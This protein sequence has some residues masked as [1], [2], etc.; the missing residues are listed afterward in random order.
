M[1][2]LYTIFIGLSFAIIGSGVV[3]LLFKN[4]EFT[5]VL[6]AISPV[7]FQFF[8]ANQ[9]SYDDLASKT[10][11]GGTL[12][13]GILAIVGVTGLIKY[14]SYMILDRGKI[15]ANILLLFL[16]LALAFSSVIYS[17]D[18]SN[19]LMR[20]SFLTTVFF[21]L[22]G[23]SVWLDTEDNF[24]K[25]LNLLFKTIVVLVIM[26]L[27]SLGI[28]GRSFWWKQP[29]FIGF[30][31]HPQQLGAFFMV[32]YPIILWKTKSE[33]QRERLFAYMILTI[34]IVL[35]LLTATRSPMFAAV[36]GILILF[37]LQRKFLNILMLSL[38]TVIAFFLMTQLNP[39]GLKRS[40]SNKMTDLTGRGEY[41]EGGML[42]LSQKPLLGYGYSAD[43]KI[44]DRQR[45]FYFGDHLGAPTSSQPLHNG[46]L[47]TAVGLGAIGLLLWL[48]VL[49]YPFYRLT[50]FKD[51]PEKPYLI[52]IMAMVLIT[53]FSDQNLTGYATIGD[54]FFWTAWLL[55]SKI[56]EYTKTN[57]LLS[58]NNTNAGNE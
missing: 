57:K 56:S 19:T 52:S 5:I 30:S 1:N 31:N 34:S 32:A 22:L 33:K 15:N 39:E 20:A 12:R 17:I 42:M 41:W 10:G 53:N 8:F 43:G 3:Y 16:F 40:E 28:P 18:K 47:S 36:L 37:L 14:L 54:T 9:V 21:A 26:H 49:T 23:G 4:Y 13:A 55:A 58:N 11:I 51:F 27:L 35:H 7:F 6:V 2:D 44:F 46:Y 25:T 48:I 29:R 38:F 24:Y 50:S 45:L